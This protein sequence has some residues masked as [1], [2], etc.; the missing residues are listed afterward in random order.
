MSLYIDVKYLQMISHRFEI[1]KRKDDYT[2]N[3][4]CPV[5]GDS[6]KNKRKMRGYFYKKENSMM[7]KCHNCSH[8]AHFGTMLKDMDS[9]LYKEYALERYANSSGYS[10]TRN[11]KTVK[12]ALPD[13]KPQFKTKTGNKL[14]DICDRLDTLPA[15]H[16]AVLYA[17]SRMIPE[18]K[19]NR[20]FFI[21]DIKNAVILNSKYKNSILTNE[22]RLVI[23]F[24]NK[25]KELTGLSL[26]G[27]RGETLR[28]IQLKIDEDAPTVFGLDAIDMNSPMTV[29]E[30]P[31]DSLFLNNAFACAGTS[32]N[33][34]E[35]L[36]LPQAN[37]TIVFD[38][39]PKNKEIVK[40]MEKYID[41]GYGICIWPES[42][43]GK[44]I[45]DMV[46]SGMDSGEI[47]NIIEVN[48]FI[49]LTAKMKLT[50]WR[51]C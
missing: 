39:Q 33:K 23:P 38:N 51:K 28:Y 5:C 35:H 4:R 46:L 7:Y 18:D 32:F 41:L 22:P 43:Q 49:N 19:F 34:I 45:N 47:Q 10:D 50:A 17:K 36:Q 13:F 21:N 6:Q 48:T 12:D 8:G 44:D 9:L 1:F 2:F 37:I 24:Y 26:R 3:V 29:V 20:L 30:G 15:D 25:D 14:E 16:E 11:K 31:L 42:I 27:M 40:L